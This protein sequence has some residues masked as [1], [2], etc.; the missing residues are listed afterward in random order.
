MKGAKHIDEA[1]NPVVGTVPSY[2]GHCDITD[3][4]VKWDYAD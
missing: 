4:G 2:V 1:W 3:L